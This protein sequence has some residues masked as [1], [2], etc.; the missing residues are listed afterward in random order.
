MS[1]FKP[2]EENLPAWLTDPSD[3]SDIAISSRARI[4]RNLKGYPYCQK[5]SPHQAKEIIEKVNNI[6][7]KQKI[8]KN[9][10]FINLKFLPPVSKTFLKERFL[11][12]EYLLQGSHK[13]I[14][15]D[16]KES[17]AILINEEDHIRIQ[18]ITGGFSIDKAYKKASSIESILEDNVEF[19]FTEHFGYLTACPTN[20]GTG[21]RI[22]VMLHL[23]GLTL[24]KKIKDMLHSLAEMG[25][26]IRGFYGEGSDSFGSIYQISNQHTLGLS[27][28]DILKKMSHVFHEI[29][30]MEI[31][32]Q[33]ELKVNNLKS[34]R[35]RVNQSFH[36]L[37]NTDSLD[38]KHS[39]E[40]LSDIRLGHLL[41]IVKFPDLSILNK[42]LILIQPM[43]L[44]NLYNISSDDFNKE[45]EDRLRATILRKYFQ[46]AKHVRTVY[47]Q[48]PTDH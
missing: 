26:S 42:L 18:A 31:K 8:S 28:K 48:S 41:K 32:V 6:L 25:F 5:I 36:L 30:S 21:L 29:Y 43:H 40:L 45:A 19:D 14:I 44:L 16:K 3:Y 12:T 11:A 33:K 37:Q 9:I 13:E 22:S 34:I 27:E 2:V 17:Y 15:A 4:A 46:G 24:K 47:S 20:T 23:P 39:L 35:D 38:L 1:F 7:K 10:M